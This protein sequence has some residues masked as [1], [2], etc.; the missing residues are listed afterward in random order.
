[1]NN[2]SDH[3]LPERV[4][5]KNPGAVPGKESDRLVCVCVCSV[6]KFYTFYFSSTYKPTHS[7]SVSGHT[8]PIKLCVIVNV[9]DG[10]I[11]TVS[12]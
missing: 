4:R 7:Q 6:L 5:D 11:E 12:M 3:K 2:Q 10:S 8:H 9:L 1:M